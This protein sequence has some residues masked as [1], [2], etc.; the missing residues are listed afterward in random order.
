MRI[1]IMLNNQ[2]F[3]NLLHLAGLV[4]NL[5]SVVDIMQNAG[6]KVS[7]S[8][9]RDWRRSP[10]SHNYRAV[11]DYAIEVI[12][13]YLFSQKEISRLSKNIK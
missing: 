5:E 12:F 10:N 8:Q 7:I 13:D 2:I 4:E 9:I 1:L 6:H 11:P 3:N